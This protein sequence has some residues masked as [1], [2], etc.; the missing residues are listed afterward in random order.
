MCAFLSYFS[1]DLGDKSMVCINPHKC[2]KYHFHLILLLWFTF[3]EYFRSSVSRLPSRMILICTRTIQHVIMCRL[4][5]QI[6]WCYTTRGVCVFYERLKIAI[7]KSDV[8]WSV[9]NKQI[10]KHVSYSSFDILLNNY[11][12]GLHIAL[13]NCSLYIII[14]YYYAP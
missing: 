1:H 8:L 13:N 5:T 7:N 12:Y 10:N 6:W 4:K 11:C 9:S 14:C 2:I 3:Y